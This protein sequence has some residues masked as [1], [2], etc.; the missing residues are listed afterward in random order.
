MVYI[1][2]VPSP[3]GTSVG[4]DIITSVL[5]TDTVSDYVAMSRIAQDD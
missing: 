5:D 4:L 1:T 2:V 3:P